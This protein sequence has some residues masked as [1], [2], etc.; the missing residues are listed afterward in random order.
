M[1]RVRV[2]CL[3]GNDVTTVLKRNYDS[4]EYQSSTVSCTKCN[5]RMVVS[6]SCEVKGR[7]EGYL[8]EPEDLK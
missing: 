5:R 3:C 1:T 2:Q 8:I 7:I 4:L 6:A